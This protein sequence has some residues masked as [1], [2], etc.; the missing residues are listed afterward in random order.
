LQ[1][2][3]AATRTTFYNQK[4]NN[5]IAHTGIEAPKAGAPLKEKDIANTEVRPDVYHTVAKMVDPVPE[6]RRKNPP[7]KTKKWDDGPNTT[8]EEDASDAAFAKKKTEKK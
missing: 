4:G 2:P 1:T 7:P 3:I 6:R 8:E 5:D